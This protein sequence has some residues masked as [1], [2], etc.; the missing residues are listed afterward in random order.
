MFIGNYFVIIALALASQVRVD[1]WMSV[2]DKYT[3][4][5]ICEY[6]CMYVDMLFTGFKIL[7]LLQL[8]KYFC[9]NR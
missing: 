2:E 1:K 9:K 6:T 3:Y 5:V 7:Y 8:A 4:I